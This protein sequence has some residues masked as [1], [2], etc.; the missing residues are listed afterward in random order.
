MVVLL[1]LL[2]LSV[3][4]TA[5]MATYGLFKFLDKKASAAANRAIILWIKG[6]NHEQLDFRRVVIGSFDSIYGKELLSVKTLIRSSVLSIVS[7]IL[8]TFVTRGTMVVRR[9]I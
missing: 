7:L 1:R 2:G 8:F 6:G 3:P 4:L 9:V 5:A